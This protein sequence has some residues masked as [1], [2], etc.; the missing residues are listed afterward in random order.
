MKPLKLL[1]IFFSD[2]F[3]SIFKANGCCVINKIAGARIL[4]LFIVYDVHRIFEL[5]RAHNLGMSM[6]M[7]SPTLILQL[8]NNKIIDRLGQLIGYILWM[9]V[10]LHSI[11]HNSRRS[12]F[13]FSCG[14]F[15]HHEEVIF[16]RE[17]IDVHSNC[18]RL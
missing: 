5:Y 11:A 9:Y 6:H 18:S 4:K 15:I 8:F 12:N 14:Y 7:Q 13:P 10:P 17:P 1:R 16:T 2:N 3:S